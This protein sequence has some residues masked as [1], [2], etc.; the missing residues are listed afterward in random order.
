[1]RT[2]KAA[3][4]WVTT[5]I[6]WVRETRERATGEGGKS[7]GEQVKDGKILGRQDAVKAFQTEGTL[8][9]EKIGDVCLLEFCRRGQS[10][11]GQESSIDAAK[12]FQPKIFTKSIEIHVC[13]IA[14]R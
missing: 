11:T 7:G 5:A 10:G 12:D 4:V 1:M 6:V 13:T 2:D 9:I 14:L 3:A 8:S